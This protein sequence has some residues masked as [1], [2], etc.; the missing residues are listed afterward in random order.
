MDEEMKRIRLEIGTV[1]SMIGRVEK[2]QMSPMRKNREFLDGVA[3]AFEEIYSRSPTK[4]VEKISYEED[5]PEEED[6]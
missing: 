5:E 6:Y 2:E 1:E 3:E 4:Q